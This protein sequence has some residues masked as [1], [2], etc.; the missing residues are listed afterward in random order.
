MPHSRPSKNHSPRRRFFTVAIIVLVG[1]M[2]LATSWSSLRS[3]S[4]AGKLAEKRN[5][6]SGGRDTAA[7]RAAS[8]N[9]LAAD[10]VRLT[11]ALPVGS[12]TVDR[13][14]DPSGIALLAAS[15]CTVAPNDCSLRGAVAFANLNLG[16]TINVPAGTYNLT[17]PGGFVE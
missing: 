15:A 9:R 13:T 3:S 4:A 14:D 12:V 11:A 10:S 8:K 17:I 2:A 5:L 6:R 1:M 16:T 7:L